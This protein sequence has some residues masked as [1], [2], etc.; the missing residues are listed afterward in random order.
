MESERI[1]E[2]K[3]P[4]SGSVTPLLKMKSSGCMFFSSLR[5]NLNPLR[6]VRPEV[7]PCMLWI[8]KEKKK[9]AK[10]SFMVQLR[11]DS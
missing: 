3:G 7:I 1:C 11:K 8:Y 5:V 2:R 9:K 10:K 6:E 4:V